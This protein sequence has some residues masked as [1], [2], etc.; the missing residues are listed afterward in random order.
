MTIL[1]MFAPNFILWN[2]SCDL[3]IGSFLEITHPLIL[4]QRL[5]LLQENF[6]LG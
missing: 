2:V 5:I 1:Y 3:P 6:K 4:H